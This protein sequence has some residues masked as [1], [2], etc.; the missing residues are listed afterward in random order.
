MKSDCSSR[1][2]RAL[3]FTQFLGALNDNIFK[4]LVSLLI[5]AQLQEEGSGSFYLGLAQALFVLPFVLFSSYAGYFVDRFSKVTIIR[6]VKVLEVVVMGLGLSFFIQGNI[7][8][9]L[10]VLFLMGFQ[11]TLFSPAKYGVL[12]EMLESRELSKGNGFLEFWTF[13]AIIL[14]TAGGSFLKWGFSER[15]LVPGIC[16][17]GISFLGLVGSFFIQKTEVEKSSAAFELNPFGRVFSILKDVREQRALFLV[18][19]GIAYFWFVAAFFQVNLIPYAQKVLGLDELGTGMLLSILAV[20]IGLGSLGAGYLSGG[21]VELGLVPLGAAGM[22]VFSLLLALVNES[23]VLASMGMFC[24]GLSAGFFSVPLNAYLQQCSPAE[25]RGSYIAVSNVLSFG[26]MLIASLAFSLLA[27]S[28]L[29]PANALFAGIGLLTVAASIYIFRLL[30][31][32]F[33]RCLNWIL[34]HSLYSLRV[35]GRQNLPEKGGALIVCN[36]VSYADAPLLLATCE[37]PIRFLIYR[38]IYEQR[39]INPVVKAMGAIPIAAEDNPKVLMRSLLEARKLI[40][41]GELVCIFAEGQLTRIGNL[42][43]F[44]KG[45]ERIVKGLDAPVIPAYLDRIWGSI[46]SYQGGRFFWKRP[47]QIPY[48]VTVSFG[49]ALPSDSKASQVRERVQQ[50]SSECFRLRSRQ[51][52]LLHLGFLRMAKRHPYRTAVVDSDGSKLSYRRLLTVNLALAKKLREILPE[53]ESLGVLFP[54]GKAGLIANLSTLFS[55]RMPVNLNYTASEDSVSSA[56]KQCNIRTVISSPVCLEKLPVKLPDSVRVLHLED[57]LKLSF[58]EKLHSLLAAIF[59]PKFI[60][61]RTLI[62]SSK[63][64]DDMATVIFSSGSTGEPKG[65]MLSHDNIASNIESLYDVFQIKKD[66][67][68]MGVLPFF[69]SFGFTGTLWLPM[70]AGIKVV[71]HNNPV[72]SS[73]IGDLIEKNKATIFMATPTF[74][75]SYMRRC[76]KEQF[77]SLRHVVVGAEKLKEKVALAFQ[78]KF[79][80]TPMEGYGCTEL[81][82]VAMLNIPDFEVDGIKQVGH[83]LGTVGHPIPGVAARIVDPDSYADLS[84]G[85]EGLLLVKGPNVMLGYLANADKTEE[86]MRDAWYITG[87]IAQ[88]DSD[89]FVTITD[90]LSRFSKI[91]GE[92]VP[93]VKIEEEMHNALGEI[94]QVLAVTAVPDEK[95]GE[96]LI[97]L[98]RK[99]INASELAKKLSGDGLPN[100]W[101]PKSENF[102]QVEELPL[103]GS[104]KLDLKKIKQIALE[105]TSA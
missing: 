69:H 105:R 79:G 60:L 46:F 11:S 94:D 76:T 101:I 20:G 78:K 55:G 19:L 5:V 26:S 7:F 98:T 97:V 18:I 47:R 30:P 63:S 24:I 68:V 22:S 45:L 66:D 85:E 35:E 59:L 17:L 53:E 15:M 2:F 90:R 64:S 71:Y 34:T 29:F 50:L 31:E 93:H 21:K 51:D 87:D 37:R 84:V 62:D 27:K 39:L 65:V 25:Q 81:S 100:L 103:L 58:S 36:H 73:T 104:G 10:L 12:P 48:P 32:A 75:L 40:E 8:A 72:D 13:L 77:A 99:E 28:S 16:V 44:S 6:L 1:S 42:L 41:Q 67:V 33:I 61:R 49:E 56:I 89:G 14:G 9:L 57:L 80:V 83:K 70:L 95:K 86:V 92:M 23:V 96:K 3:L 88:I 102:F 82:P 52:P 43:A 91:G 38:D 54:P 4:L 74:L